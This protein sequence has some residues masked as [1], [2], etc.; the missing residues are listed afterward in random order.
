MYNISV[1]A[2]AMNEAI[3]FLVNPFTLISVTLM[4][5]ITF[6]AIRFYMGKEYFKEMILAA[7][8]FFLMFGVAP[9]GIIILCIKTHPSVN[10]LKFSI[11][12]IPVY[13]LFFLTI[14]RPNVLRDL[15]TRKPS[16]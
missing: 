1:G 9:I 3:Q 10:I 7:T 15:K 11:A 6:C 14:L 12:L 4:L 5:V 2:H 13:C 8:L 16:L